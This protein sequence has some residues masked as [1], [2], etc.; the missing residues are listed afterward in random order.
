[1]LVLLFAVAAVVAVVV[2]FIVI[3]IPQKIPYQLNMK[4]H[5]CT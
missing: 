1:M 2:V 5:F 4:M 3:V